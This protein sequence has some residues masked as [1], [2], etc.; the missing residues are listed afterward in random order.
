MENNIATVILSHDS[1]V[2]RSEKR[3]YEDRLRVENI[4]TKSDLRMTL[5]VVSDGIGGENA[6]ERAAQKTVDIIFEYCLGSTSTDIPQ[7]LEAAIVQA[8]KEVFTESKLLKANRNMGATAVVA[9]ICN[10]RLYVAN[11]GD[12]RIYLIRGNEIKQITIDH[13]WGME[14][15]RAKKLNF[16]EAMR[17]PRKDELIRSI[18]YDAVVNVDLGLYLHG[19]DE[20]EEE[21]RKAQ[22]LPLLP[23]DKI[24]LCSDGLIKKM[25]YTNKHFVEE[26]EIVSIVN[27]S[28]PEDSAKNL[29]KQALQR[30]ANDNVSA[31]VLE[32]P[33]GRPKFSVKK[34][35]KYA[36]PAIVLIGVVISIFSGVMRNN[37]N[38]PLATLPPIEYGQVLIANLQKLDL[39]IRDIGGNGNYYKQGDLIDFKSGTIMQTGTGAEGFIRLGFSNQAAVYLAE[40]TEIVLDTLN[41]TETIIQL[42]KG[43][44]VVQLPEGSSQGKS[45]RVKST[46]GSQAKIIGSIMGVI[47]DSE[48]SYFRM[49]CFEGTCYSSTDD[50]VWD[51]ISVGWHII[52]SPLEQREKSIGTLNEFWVFVPQLIPTPTAIIIPTEEPTMLPSE[53]FTPAGQDFYT[54]QPGYTQPAHAISTPTFTVTVTTPTNTATIT[55]SAFPVLPFTPTK[56]HTPTPS[57]TPSPTQSPSPSLSPTNTFTPRSTNTKAPTLTQTLTLTPSPTSTFTPTFT[58]TFTPTPTKTKHK[59]D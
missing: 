23:G 59:T 15:Y 4:I 3:F 9:A 45:F 8:N 14:V 34:I 5:A 13:S 51:S 17:H 42:N 48:T 26:S 27:D 12:S 36:L 10:Q 53:K 56:S 47:Y 57:N 46:D 31:I 52:L 50:E 33:G 7:M 49:D 44:I 37:A 24:L 11:V 43:R 39:F 6:G 30:G 32:I 2:G 19:V 16:D 1:D 25:K 21:A 55:T 58:Y 18:G 54:P 40:N 29:V 41:D 20:P 38:K 22:G 28:K 35:V